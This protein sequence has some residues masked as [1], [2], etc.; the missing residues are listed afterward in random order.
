MSAGEGMSSRTWRPFHPSPI[1]F[2]DLDT[3]M[4]KV[5]TPDE[6][7]PR[8]EKLETVYAAPGLEYLPALR[9]GLFQ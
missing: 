7:D 6:T 8:N 1:A 3:T 2:E 4:E 9:A 5:R